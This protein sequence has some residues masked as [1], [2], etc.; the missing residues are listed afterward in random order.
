M[1]DN[2]SLEEAIDYCQKMEKAWKGTIS[3]EGISDFYK[4]LADT[5]KKYLQIKQAV[6][7]GLLALVPVVPTLDMLHGNTS[8]EYKPKYIWSSMLIDAPKSELLGDDNG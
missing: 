7:A 2:L 8:L 3:D 6:D 5:A 4:L 1:T